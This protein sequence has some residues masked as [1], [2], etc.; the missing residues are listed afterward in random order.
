MNKF[1]FYEITKDIFELPDDKYYKAHCISA[2][3]KLGA[4]IAKLFDQKYDIKRR[5]FSLEEEREFPDCIIV[6]NVF[7]L[8]TKINYWD[9]PTYSTI[10][11]A[12]RLFKDLVE[13]HSI[14][15]IAIPLLGCGLDKLDWEI[16]R[17]IIH[18][19]FKDTD[20]TMIVCHNPKQYKRRKEVQY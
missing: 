3:Y 12:I 7:N 19:E 15:D 16:V 20:C 2:D 8:V 10:K 17:K 9:K 13:K 11:V 14:R 5:L 6:D 18:E 4:G 1:K